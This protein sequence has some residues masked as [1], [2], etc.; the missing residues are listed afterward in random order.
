MVTATGALP[1]FDPVQLVRDEYTGDGITLGPDALRVH[2]SINQKNAIRANQGLY[3]RFWYFEVT[4]FGPARNVGC[5]AVIRR[6][7]LNP[8]DFL[9]TQ[10]S[11]QVNFEG[12]AWRDLIFQANV[13]R[14]PTV[15]F[16]IDY[17]VA[18]SVLRA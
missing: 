13:D 12:S 9:S 16:A 3:G 4:R 11:V 5:G 6:G 15:G 1:Q 14:D 17:T 10:P 18:L 8:L 2:Y 7:S